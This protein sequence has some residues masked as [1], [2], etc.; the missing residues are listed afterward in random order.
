MKKQHIKEIICQVKRGKEKIMEKLN[1]V[2]KCS[3]FGPQNLGSRGGSGPR[4]PPGSAPGNVQFWLLTRILENIPGQV[5]QLV[6]RTSPSPAFGP[7]RYRINCSGHLWDVC[8]WRSDGFPRTLL[9][10]SRGTRIRCQVNVCRN[11]PFSISNI[12]IE[13]W[14]EN[15]GFVI[16]M[17]NSLKT[18]NYIREFLPRVNLSPEC[19]AVK[20]E[21]LNNFLSESRLIV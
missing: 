11:S 6:M 8:R 10:L 15:L 16:R 19:N 9:T 21:I 1:R 18:L 3:N 5:S 14:K 17:I 20:T 13:N 7:A 12:Y 4:P 2:Q